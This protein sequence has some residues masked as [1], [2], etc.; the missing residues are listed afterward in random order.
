MQ[1]L[2]EQLASTDLKERAAAAGQIAASFDQTLV[3]PLAKKSHGNDPWFE[4]VFCRFLRNLPPEVSIPHLRRLLQKLE[5]PF[6][7]R[8]KQ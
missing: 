2:L 3:E 7:W 8:S 4:S 5:Q 1:S 6:R